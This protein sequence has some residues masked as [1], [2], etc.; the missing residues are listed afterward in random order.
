VAPLFS[1]QK[2][3]SYPQNPRVFRALIA[4]QYNG[5]EIETT[6]DF[7]MGKDNKTKEFLAL[8]PN[9]KVP[10][11]VTDD[12]PIFETNAIARFVAHANPTTQ[13]FGANAYESGLVEQWIDWTNGELDLPAAAWIYPILGFVPNNEQVGVQQLALVLVLSFS[14]SLSLSLSLQHATRNARAGD[15]QGKARKGIDRGEV[16]KMIHMLQLSLTEQHSVDTCDS[17]QQLSLF[18]SQSLDS[19]LFGISLTRS[20]VLTRNR[21]PPRPRARSARPLLC[22]TPTSSAA[23]SSS[24]SA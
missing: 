14:L 6:P 11:L 24:V 2:I 7:Q 1:E 20:L 5:I 16:A 12:G 8:N 19:R 4:G 23:R 9:G 21:P 15:G 3:Y 10:V 18:L 22:S 13:L 17:E